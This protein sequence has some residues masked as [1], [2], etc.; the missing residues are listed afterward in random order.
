V[1]VQH[2]QSDVPLAEGGARLR[3]NFGASGVGGASISFS[4]FKAPGRDQGALFTSIIG[5]PEEGTL[6]RRG[7]C[8]WLTLDDAQALRAWLNEVLP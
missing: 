7:H 4:S 3:S 5:P 2:F 1:I 8:D 6:T